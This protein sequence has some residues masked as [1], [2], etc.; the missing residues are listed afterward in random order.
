M[1]LSPSTWITISRL[2][3]LLVIYK[4]R[5]FILCI[6]IKT[7]IWIGLLPHTINLFQP[8]V[9]NS[10][11]ENRNLHIPKLDFLIWLFLG[12][13]CIRLT[14]WIEAVFYRMCWTIKCIWLML[15]RSWV[16]WLILHR[17]S[18]PTKPW[19][20]GWNIIGEG[21][22]GLGIGCLKGGNN[23][24]VWSFLSR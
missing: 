1:P 21:P 14:L 4:Y 20:I 2:L 15:C 12:F 9:A 5:L 24:V 7:L 11:Q 3:M 22:Q 8:C 17:R 13:C 19:S 16:K 6:Q 10:S 23:V 18:I